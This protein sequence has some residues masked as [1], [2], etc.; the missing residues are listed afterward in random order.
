MMPI[1]RYKHEGRESSMANVHPDRL[2][3][4]NKIKGDFLIFFM[5]IICIFCNYYILL[6]KEKLK[7]MC[8]YPKCF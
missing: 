5:F 1:H 8:N 3:S 2:S 6:L 7:Q 4:I